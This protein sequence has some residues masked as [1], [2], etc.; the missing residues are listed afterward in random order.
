M[1]TH[2]PGPWTL[3]SPTVIHHD[4]PEPYDSETVSVRGANGAG[5]VSLSGGHQHVPFVGIEEYRANARLIA[6]APELLEACKHFVAGGE[7]R[8]MPGYVYAKEAIAK[9]EG[10]R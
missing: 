10:Q 7:A 8:F 2:T 3:G 9:A 5:I 6:A 4:Y 1:S